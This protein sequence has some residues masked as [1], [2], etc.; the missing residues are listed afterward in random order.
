MEEKVKDFDKAVEQDK[1]NNEEV[2]KKI[3]KLKAQIEANKIKTFKFV[4]GGVSDI[5]GHYKAVKNKRR[6]L[7]KIQKASRKAN[8]RRG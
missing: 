5:N 4:A 8:R 6:R 2:D 7:A 1:L 3:E